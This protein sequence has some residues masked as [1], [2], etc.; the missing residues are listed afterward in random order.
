MRAFANHDHLPEG[1]TIGMR[2]KSISGT[3]DGLLIKHD[4]NVSGRHVSSPMYNGS[5]DGVLAKMPEFVYFESVGS[6]TALL[7]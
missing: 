2:E 3:K 7:A 4:T 1:F 6:G 5:C